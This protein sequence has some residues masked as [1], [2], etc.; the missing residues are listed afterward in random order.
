MPFLFNVLALRKYKGKLSFLPVTEYIPKSSNN[1]T[2][3][4]VNI[5]HNARRVSLNSL[6]GTEHPSDNKLRSKSVPSQLFRGKSVDDS[7][8]SDDNEG[9]L[10]DIGESFAAGDFNDLDGE[11]STDVNMEKPAEKGDNNS[12]HDMKNGSGKSVRSASDL[13]RVSQNGTKLSAVLPPINE[14]VPSNWVTLEDEFVTICATYQTH[15]GSDLIM[16]PEAHFND[17][18]IHLCFIK[19]GIQKSELITLMGLLEKGT[20]IDHPS[21]NLEFIKCLA[22]RI[23]PE[24]NEGIIMVDGEKVDSAPIQGQV[25]PGLANLMAIQ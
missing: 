19:A 5:P 22:F 17:G 23:E 12:N 13:L 21:P 9:K 6:D 24:D 8:E 2:T 20:H 1:N 4:A 3:K 15:L 11:T 7:T 18:I 14:P 16:A 10:T 25:M